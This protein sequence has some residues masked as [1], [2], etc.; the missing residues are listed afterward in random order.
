MVRAGASLLSCHSLQAPLEPGV[1]LVEC[2][3]ILLNE[4]L[5]LWL[6]FLNSTILKPGSRNYSEDNIGDLLI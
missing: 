1:S 2:M 6:L 3:D 4:R 5:F